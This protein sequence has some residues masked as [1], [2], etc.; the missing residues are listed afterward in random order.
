MKKVYLLML[1]L[2]LALG[3]MGLGYAL[4]YENLYI[5]GYA[6]TGEL[7]WEFADPVPGGGWIEP[8]M[9]HDDQGLDPLIPG[10]DLT[11]KDVAWKEWEFRDTDGDG[12]KDTLVFWIKNGYPGYWNNISV[13]VHN[14]GTIPL[15]YE[16]V[17]LNGQEFPIGTEVVLENGAIAFWWGD[18]PGDQIHPCEGTEL[19]FYVGVLQP[20]LQNHTYEIHI[21]LGA[22]NYNESIYPILTLG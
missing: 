4:W 3:T 12:D 10:Y 2:V 14:N 8:I 7:D 17:L 15:H 22:V 9:H 5:D 11:V 13:H 20:A 1:A 6:E 21:T 16:Y 18:R 19:S